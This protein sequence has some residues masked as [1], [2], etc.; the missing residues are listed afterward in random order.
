MKAIVCKESGGPEVLAL[1]DLP[2]P[3]P[4][5]D[6][7]LVRVRASALNRA[8]TLQ[9]RGLY[10]PPPGDSEVL[11]LELAGE[12]AGWGSNV[13]GFTEGERVFG[14]VGGGGYGEYALLDAKMAMPIPEGWDYL[15]AAA[16]P[17]VFFT[18]NETVFVLGGL[19]QGES[20][21]VH[22][23]G[24]GVGTAVIQMAHHI[25]AKV[26]F[27]AGSKEKIDGAMALG[28]DAGINYKTQDFAQEVL[29]LTGGHG[30]DVVEDF[31]GASY[32]EK[33]MEVLA[34]G[35]RLVLVATMGG[36]KAEINLNLVMRKRLRIFGS[37]MRSRPL[38]DKREIT[39]RFMERW[40]PVLSA[41][42]IKPIIDSRFP[43]AEAVQAHERM[44]A[45]L[46]FGKIMLIVD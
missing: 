44:E 5:A 25:G 6:D 4:K 36:I 16:V 15:E 3:E 1:S 43:L 24:S 22:A 31:L 37:V 30:V 46:N 40:L 28:A 9:R 39:R 12:V 21:L 8:D 14:L 42:S 26:Y 18:A 45:N 32:L 38:Q 41:G 35:G 29:K 17:E 11:G 23:G 13:S 20:L 2:T 27:T 19:Q 33:N 7:L 10:P 34:T